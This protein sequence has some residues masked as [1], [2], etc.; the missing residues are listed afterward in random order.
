MALNPVGTT[1]AE[2]GVVDDVALDDAFDDDVAFDDVAFDDGTDGL[3]VEPPPDEQAAITN[4]IAN[5]RTVTSGGS[6][7]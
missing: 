3:A 2:G 4:A 6:D 7:R 1:G 5:T